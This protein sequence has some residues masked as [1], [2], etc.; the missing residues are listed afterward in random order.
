[1]PSVKLWAIDSQPLVVQIRDMLINTPVAAARG[2]GIG[3]TG[4]KRINGGCLVV[5]QF[6]PPMPWQWGFNG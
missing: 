2:L 3:H 6:H 5:L 1:M 4:Q